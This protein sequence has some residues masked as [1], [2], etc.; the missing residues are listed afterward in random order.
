[1]NYRQ[2]IKDL[3]TDDD[4]NYKLGLENAITPERLLAHM[5][6]ENWDE[7]TYQCARVELNAVCT[8][9]MK[10][11]YVAGGI[12]RTPT[13][14]LIAKNPTEEGYIL[15]GAAQKLIGR[16]RNFQ[17]RGKNQLNGRV[18]VALINQASSLCEDERE[19]YGPLFEEPDQ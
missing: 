4:G 14:Y 11:C 1:M 6:I 5:G 7:R 8:M 10:E 9:V 16:L 15:R 19:E 18:V 12:S 13:H 2:A 3:W 17:R